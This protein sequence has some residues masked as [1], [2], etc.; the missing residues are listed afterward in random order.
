MQF[1]K[2]PYSPE[3]RNLRPGKMPTFAHKFRYL[4]KVNR[5]SST[6]PKIKFCTC[7]ICIILQGKHKALLTH[8]LG[9]SYLPVSRSLRRYYSLQIRRALVFS[10]V[11][12]RKE[13]VKGG[14]DVF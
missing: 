3:V 14:I 11:E 12:V 6:E 8:F 13:D 7:V 2:K 10:H 4:T 1:R 5:S 9:Y